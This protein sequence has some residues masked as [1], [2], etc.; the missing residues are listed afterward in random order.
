[1][2]NLNDFNSLISD[3]IENISTEINLLIP[4]YNKLFN[5]ENIFTS[6]NGVKTRLHRQIFNENHELINLHI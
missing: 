2:N 1:M 4:I 6:E 3:N 5:I